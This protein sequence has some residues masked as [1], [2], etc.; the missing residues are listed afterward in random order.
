MIK[1]FSLLASIGFVRMA[2]SVPGGNRGV[3]RPCG[4]GRSP[5]SVSC[6]AIQRSYSFD[7]S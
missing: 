6:V 2:I 4:A 7:A 1:S 3:G 5:Q